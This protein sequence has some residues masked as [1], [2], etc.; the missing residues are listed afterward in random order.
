MR[1]SAESFVERTTEN[2]NLDGLKSLVQNMSREEFGKIL[3]AQEKEVL[4]V[5][6]NTV[7]EETAEKAM[8]EGDEDSALKEVEVDK[9]GEKMIREQAAIPEAILT[10]TRCSPRLVD[11]VDEH[12]MSKAERRAATRNLEHMEGNRSINSQ[13]STSVLDAALNVQQLGICFGEGIGRGLEEVR[14]FISC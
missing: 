12:T 6:V 8:A 3:V 14:S 4:D 1:S 2:W 11:S 9:P 10:P 5:A 13:C 7:L